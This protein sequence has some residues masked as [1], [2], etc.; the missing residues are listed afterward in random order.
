MEENDGNDGRTHRCEVFEYLL[1]DELLRRA[2]CFSFSSAPRCKPSYLVLKRCSLDAMIRDD[3]TK[4][5]GD[6]T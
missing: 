6:V 2:R 1:S 4:G 5:C 3:V